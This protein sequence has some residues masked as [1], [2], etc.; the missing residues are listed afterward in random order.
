MRS[1]R[2]KETHLVVGGLPP[3]TLDEHDRRRLGGEKRELLRVGPS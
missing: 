3:P 2:K 1:R